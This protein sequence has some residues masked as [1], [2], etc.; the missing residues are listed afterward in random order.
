MSIS[1]YQQQPSPFDAIRRTR[2]DGTEYWSARDLMPLMGYPTWQHF[3]PTIERGRA[4]AA[5]QGADPD[6]NF[7]V[8]REVSGARGPARADVHL[9]RFAAYLVAMNG[10]PR[11]PEVAAAQAYFAIRTRE[12]E[13]ARPSLTGPALVAAALIEANAMLES[14]RKWSAALEAKVD[15]DR[16]KVLFADAVAASESTI[17]VGE[18]AKIL[19]GNGFDIGGTR[20]F[21]LLRE[22]GYLIK[23]QGSDWNMPT[24]KSMDLGLFRI[25]ETAITHA[26]GHTTVSKT[27]KVTGKG[28]AYFIERYATRLDDVA[29]ITA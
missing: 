9:S 1:T 14:E 12:A 20:L 24:Q 5:N 15:E 22:E 28:Q 10:D 17:L 27:P 7:T 2:P 16:P 13:T 6:G 26:D 11:K 18:L 29:A 4:A 21:A 25:K 23:R 8:A 3:E 19:K